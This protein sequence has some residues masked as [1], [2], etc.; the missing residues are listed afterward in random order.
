MPAFEPEA[1]ELDDEAIAEIG[2]TT[3]SHPVGE[4]LTPSASGR[5]LW[6]RPTGGALSPVRPV[7]IV[8][9]RVRTEDGAP[10]AGTTLRASL[11]K[12]GGT[13][14]TTE[15]V[16][17]PTGFTSVDFSDHEAEGTE[18]VV[19][20]IVMDPEKGTAAEGEETVVTRPD[21]DGKPAS[22]VFVKDG[23]R[24][25][26]ST[27]LGGL[28]RWRPRF[29]P[30]YEDV[31][32]APELF[33]PAVIERDGTC[34]LDF[35]SE[36]D[37]HTVTFNQVIRLKDPGPPRTG[38]F[39]DNEIER[40]S[41]PF[42][43]PLSYA[44]DAEG[45][46]PVQAWF[47]VPGILNVYT[48]RWTRVGHGLGSILYSLALAPCEETRI[49]VIE[50]NRTE[51]ARR[52]EAVETDERLSHQI[53]RDR[54]VSE[55]VDSV[56][57]EV[58][59]GRSSTME[60]GL[61]LSLGPI[62]LGGGGGTSASQ[63]SGART[64]AM[65]TAQQLADQTEQQSSS[66]RKLRSTV[67]TQASATEREE[68]T[69]RTVRNS[70][71]SHALTVQYFQVVEHH[72][73]ETALTQQI[74]VLLVPYLVPGELFDEF[75]SFEA[76]GGS[77]V[78][79]PNN[80]PGPQ[81]LQAVGNGLVRWL[82]A[83][84]EHIGE[85]V[86]GRLR[87]GIAA[88]QRLLHAPEIYEADQP[89]V[90]AS[91]WTIE[92]AGGWRPGVR[93][94]LS[95]AEGQVRVLRLVN[96][97][98]GDTILKAVS[99]PVEIRSV[100][101]LTVSWESSRD[102]T[103]VDVLKS[104]LGDVVSWLSGHQGD[105]A[106]E[107][108][109]QLTEKRTFRLDT[110]GLVVTAHTEASKWLPR[111]GSYA[112][113]PPSG[114]DIVIPLDESQPS[115]K[116]PASRPEIDILETE[117][118]R[119]RDYAA[120]RDLALHVRRHAMSYLKHLWLTEDPDERALRFDRY[121]YGPS[122]NRRPLLDV[123]EN[124]PIGVSGNLVAF[125]LLEGG[126]TS[127]ARLMDSIKLRRLVTLP[128]DGVFSEVFLSACKA[129]EIRDV[130]RA[131]DEQHACHGGAPEITGVQ[132]RG[133][134][135]PTIPGSANLPASMLSIQTAPGAPAPSGLG[136]AAQVLGQPD[137][138]RDMSLG[139]ETV[140][141]AR[142]LAQQATVTSGEN[143]RAAIDALVTLLTGGLGGAGRSP[144]SAV[145]GEGL[146]TDGTT[147]STQRM[148]SGAM[149]RD[150]DPVRIND[151]LQNLRQAR[152]A[153]QI[154]TDGERQG[155]ENLLGIVPETP[156]HEPRETTGRGERAPDDSVE[157]L[158]SR[159]VA[160]LPSDAND[161][162]R[163]VAV[164]YFA[165]RSPD[166]NVSRDLV[167]SL[168]ED[169]RAVLDQ[170]RHDAAAHRQRI[171]VWGYADARPD[172]T[173]ENPSLNQD[174]SI[175]RAHAVEEYL[176]TPSNPFST[177]EAQG[178]GDEFSDP[179]DPDAFPA[180]RRVEILASTFDVATTPRPTPQR[181]FEEDDLRQGLEGWLDDLAND[182]PEMEPEV[183]L[184][185]IQFVRAYVYG[186]YLLDLF[187][188][189]VLHPPRGSTHGE[190]ARELFVSGASV[191]NVQRL[192]AI[193]DSLVS[194]L[195]LGG[196]TSADSLVRQV[197]HQ[198]NVRADPFYAAAYMSLYEGLDWSSGRVDWFAVEHADPPSE[199]YPDPWDDLPSRHRE[200]LRRAGL[201]EDY[202]S[203]AE[204][205]SHMRPRLHVLHRCYGEA[206]ALV[207]ANHPAIAGV[208]GI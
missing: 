111:A 101:G 60:A 73:V 118:S 114:T 105:V 136:A 113:I 201:A 3:I 133:G 32:A 173:G 53:R 88:L 126:Q 187:E 168:G 200:A 92:L 193:Q 61:G 137:L 178:F 117:S 99:E 84:G 144:G 76:F 121:Q 51:Q 129:T 102:E 18:V 33:A 156:R 24:G 202:L 179:T 174:L 79:Q 152:A 205:R 96:P 158:R 98:R 108:V 207:R 21:M 165:T 189:G 43:R 132:P 182:P 95:A 29:L 112:I 116:L 71:R 110:S 163:L 1:S 87:K 143:Q 190:V 203:G 70:N 157:E 119:Y 31:E 188:R 93:F 46:H 154:S 28:S 49:A 74:D 122:S 106:R 197:R 25:I 50:W 166:P 183:K 65:N 103:A 123:I 4:L 91:R 27:R 56:L 115:H 185:G 63:S 124:R 142:A 127:E 141:A 100:E 40:L 6:L 10:A 186:C 176:V 2:P 130:T 198:K 145:D 59:A 66:R 89:E 138:F 80:A 44:H 97:S 9:L 159:L 192:P 94:R 155:A 22:F 57:E 23:F 150:S 204:H 5:P 26:D 72:T 58:Q 134:T 146:A 208:M 67:V 83:Y 39:T 194:G 34:A 75:P 169:D 162:T 164:I 82:D 171:R 167:E 199:P 135:A 148:A 81:P 86:P 160:P 170:L 8:R 196:V 47:A 172:S 54:T 36:V 181:P 15:V 38:R 20:P 37:T 16:V 104:D 17:G 151:Q 90:L 64:L 13:L 45:N 35:R 206:H 62:V 52:R 147:T 30:E 107:L 42:P 19:Q 7:G 177:V 85:A 48:Q 11:R 139:A 120:A 69:T 12:D 55:A 184:K 191:Q 149:V 77:T 109:D 161:G 140:A 128:T 68:I 131:V 180:H 175:L 14:A 78:L 153:G 41:H 125:P 195:E